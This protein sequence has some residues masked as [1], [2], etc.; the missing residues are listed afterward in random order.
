MYRNVGVRRH[1]LQTLLT[2]SLVLVGLATLVGASCVSCH[3]ISGFHVVRFEV[4]EESA[5]V[6]VANYVKNRNIIVQF[7]CTDTLKER[8]QQSSGEI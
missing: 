1:T 2:I 3:T 6:N 4:G 8:L 7:M 5:F